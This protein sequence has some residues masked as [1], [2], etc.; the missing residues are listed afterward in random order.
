MAD[1]AGPDDREV[2]A[3]ELA[4]LNAKL[5]A[6]QARVEA[7][8]ILHR[9]LTEKVD[10]L[11][12]TADIQRASQ[13]LIEERVA[14][15]REHI[16]ENAR[17]IA[18]ILQS[19][20][21]R[22]F[23]AVGGWILPVR[24]KAIARSASQ[25]ESASTPKLTQ[26]RRAAEVQQC[27]A[28]VHKKSIADWKEKLRAAAQDLGPLQGTPS[29]S[30]ITPAFNS[31]TWWLAEAALSVFQQTFRDWEWCIVDDC[32]DR[33]EFH[34][35][36]V[37]LET[38]SRI[39]I[40]RLDQRGGIS[41]AL[42]RGLE[43]ARS[44]FVCFLDHDDV[45][46]PE[47]LECCHS[48]LSH[49][50]DAVYTDEDKISESGVRHTPLPKP[51]W[52]PEFFRWVMYIGHL[53]CV[54]RDLALAAGGFRSEYDRIQD[55]EFMLRYSERTQRIGHV[56]KI[57]YHWRAVDGSVAAAQD[58]KGDL[59]PLQVA[60]AQAHLDRLGLAASALPGS[61]THMLRLNPKA[62]ANTPNVSI[63]LAA[64]GGLEKLAN[65][66][67]SLFGETTY[68]ALE[69][70]C[71]AHDASST[72]A[73]RLVRDF[74]I[75]WL[76][77][78][79]N[80]NI[81]CANNLGARHASGSFIVFLA[82]DVRVLSPDW[83]DQMLYYAEQDD[84]GCVG[85]LLIRTNETV[86]HAGIMISSPTE[87]SER[88]W[89]FATGEPDGY[90]GSL[91]CAH[92]VTGVSGSCAMLRRGLFT[93]VGEFDPAMISQ[94]RDIDLCLRLRSHHKRIIFTPSAA[95]LDASSRADKETSADE[96][97]L[98]ERWGDVLRA[99]DPYYKRNAV[100]S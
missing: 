17:G 63:V 60:A 38:K 72:V 55:Y 46:E 83:V 91:A 97:L 1:P 28:V 80:S 31:Q 22:T 98:V 50:F 77:D 95:F 59:A 64:E 27:E 41:A 19:R 86:K 93:E 90:W 29:I 37:E 82:E 89:R 87:H 18:S 100:V 85:G 42:N 66:L 79:C 81:A 11:R 32:S 54:R 68:S 40:I 69:V 45:L 8:E 71:V 99:G 76:S 47:A 43:L 14:E 39:T 4:R 5:W 2:T 16:E 26:A 74:P 67:V 13:Q 15:Q 3:V 9:S 48:V 94:C 23:T 75:K 35:L 78:T 62:R 57:L 33:V 52:S 53:L 92:E 96:T 65:C 34:Q 24:R 49:S 56:S 25:N 36:F 20:I 73:G 88:G 7:Q 12:A 58:A 10:D 21:W 61:R 44:K 6:L 30:I 84:I 51:D 70:L